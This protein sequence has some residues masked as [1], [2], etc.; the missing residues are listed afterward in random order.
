MFFLILFNIIEGNLLLKRFFDYQMLPMKKNINLKI[1]MP[2]NCRK[3][4]TGYSLKAMKM[5]YFKGMNRD[6]VSKKVS[7]KKCKK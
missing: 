7:V 6:Y 2:T 3:E 4:K 5:R 1:N